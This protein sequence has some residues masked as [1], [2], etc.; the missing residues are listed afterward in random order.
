M[1][2]NLKALGLALAAVLALSAV[3]A[4]AASAQFEYEATE[5]RL[6]VSSNEPLSQAGFDGEGDLPPKK[7]SRDSG[8]RRPVGLRVDPRIRLV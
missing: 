1:I 6:T 2:R 5:N 4:S 7:W 3:V 8:I